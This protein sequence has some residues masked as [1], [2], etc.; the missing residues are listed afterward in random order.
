MSKIDVSKHS[1][2]HTLFK[3]IE[4]GKWQKETAENINVI[5]SE[6]TK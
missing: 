1:K 3:H 5:A 2:I 6:V 4:L